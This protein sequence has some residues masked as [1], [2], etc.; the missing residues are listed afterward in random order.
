MQF[1]VYS[2]LF[3]IVTIST[4]Y[5]NHPI[6]YCDKVFDSV[7]VKTN[8]QYGS[9]VTAAG[10]RE[11]LI[12][13]LYE[14]YNDTS[15]TRALLVFIHGGAFMQGNKSDADMVMFCRTFA[16][17]GY[18][19]VSI[20][21]RIDPSLLLN[22]TFKAFAQAV[23]RA[24]QDA[25]AAVRYLRANKTLYKLDDKKIMVGGTSAG[26]VTSLHYAYMD[27]NEIPSVVDTLTIGGIEGS[28]GTPGV[29]TAINGIINCWG[30]I[31]DST[32]LLNNRLPVI[33]FHGTNDKIVPF[34]AGVAL[35]NPNLPMYGSACV[36]RVLARTGVNTVFKPFIGM[37]HGFSGATD[38]RADTTIA[39]MT[40]FI[41]AILFSINPIAVQPV[42]YK[43][44]YTANR[45][46]LILCTPYQNF[47]PALQKPAYLFSV[48]GKIIRL[49]N[50]R[51]DL[52]V[53]NR[54]GAGV[55]IIGACL[56]AKKPK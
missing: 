10:V 40:D 4:G 9:N 7:V 53:N 33:S 52:R 37:G 44:V 5:S 27:A 3:L 38:P 39:M 34:D 20:N 22:Q 36:H 12:L 31:G 43:P 1:S 13:D 16:Q 21:Y 30:A 35:G 11:S 29:S 51:D 55:Y 47:F 19:A 8:I 41:Y 15:K 50:A 18:V 2:A 49:I 17:K 26:G 45:A 6:R 48:N 56:P 46:G 54:I 24:V 42:P 25:K 23:L 32:W 14:P 28:S